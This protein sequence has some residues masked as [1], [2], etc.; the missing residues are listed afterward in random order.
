MFIS[1]VKRKYIVADAKPDV[2]QILSGYLEA[3]LWSSTD[4]DE[5]NKNLDDKYDVEDIS[6]ELEA[7]SI[8][9]I[10]TFLKKAEEKGVDL[11]KYNNSQIGHDLWLTRAGHGAGFWDGDYKL[12]EDGKDGDILTEIAEALGNREPYVGDDGKIYTDYM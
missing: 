4:M 3:M 5:G 12:D 8:K 7:A 6:D 11:S 1:K 2:D 9:D 10:E